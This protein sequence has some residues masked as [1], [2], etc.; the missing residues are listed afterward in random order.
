MTK[1]PIV[2]DGKV[3]GHRVHKYDAWNRL[4]EIK[5]DQD[6]VVATMKYDGL[7]RRIYKAITNSGDMNATYKFFYDGRRVIETRNGSDNV[8]K[9]KVWGPTY[10]DELVQVATN[11]NPTVDDDMDDSYVI[12]DDANFNVIG[13]MNDDHDLIERREYH[14]YGRRQVFING[15]NDSSD[16]TCKSEIPHPQVVVLGLTPQAYSICDEGHQGLPH[17]KEI[18]VLNNRARY[19]SPTL[20]RSTGRDPLDYIDGNN[21]YAYLMDNPANGLDPTGTERIHTNGS[22]V[23]W[24][25]EE[26][27]TFD[28]SDKKWVWIGKLHGSE[29]EIQIGFAK[30]K[31]FA[32]PKSNYRVSLATLK[33]Q[34]ENWWDIAGVFGGASNI[35]GARKAA[36]AR[37]AAGSSLDEVAGGFT[38]GKNVGKPAGEVADAT[39]NAR[40]VPSG[41]KSA[42]DKS[43]KSKIHGKA[44]PT[45]TDGHRFRT[46]REAIAEAKNPD[47]K[48]VH[49]DH[50]YN[51]GLDLDPKT[52]T[53]N[54]RPDVLSVYNDGKVVRVEVQSTTDVP[55]IL[56]SRNAALDAQLRSR[57]FK[58]TPPR[59]VQPTRR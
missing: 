21:L 56:R 1:V 47:V 40:K 19:T 23:W 46:Y 43:W 55:A 12:L 30:G 10:V 49:L 4:V 41:S 11:D 54:R 44:H 2:K 50:G 20:C 28:N 32:T 17:D 15:P 16:Y 53:P 13:M 58:P 57:G 31:E 6:D 51:R 52:I 33:A 39:A 14:P 59:V 42:V 24:I 3:I 5:N 18:D 38:S 27:G 45:G 22:D 37:R 36:A 25:I 29:V 7:G 34:T 9:H 35:A 8:I 48:S 26:P